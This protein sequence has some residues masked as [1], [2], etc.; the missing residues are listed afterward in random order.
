MATASA[1]TTASESIP[2]PMPDR[3][4]K[5]EVTAE[6]RV[7]YLLHDRI[8]KTK[9]FVIFTEKNGKEEFFSQECGTCNQEVRWYPHRPSPRERLAARELLAQGKSRNGWKTTLSLDEEV[10]IT[11]TTLGAFPECIHAAKHEFRSL[12][13]DP[14][15]HDH[16]PFAAEVQQH[17]QS[18][19]DT[20]ARVYAVLE[21]HRRFRA[22][23]AELGIIE[24]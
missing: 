19:D 12:I 2:I 24:L 11:I 16:I 14:C 22:R 5:R 6:R 10:L 21:Q 18:L 20:V 3:H 15:N 17:L 4:V 1:T 7:Q 23:A 8:T 13:V 9:W